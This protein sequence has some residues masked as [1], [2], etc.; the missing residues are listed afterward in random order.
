[1]NESLKAALIQAAGFALALAAIGFVCWLF[2]DA[3]IGLA[4]T[5]LGLVNWFAGKLTGIPLPAVTMQA[6]KSLPPR[7][8]KEAIRILSMRPV[9]PNVDIRWESDDEAETPHER[10]KSRGPDSGMDS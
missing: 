5:A 2:P 8:A 1:M 9:A 4:V 3:K 7:R 6:I 10:P